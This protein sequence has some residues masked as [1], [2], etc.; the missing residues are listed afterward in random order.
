MGLW[1][2]IKQLRTQGVMGINQRNTDYILKYNKRQ[3]YPL[4]DNKIRTKTLAQRA[5]IGVP[6]LYGV[7][8][9]ERQLEQLAEFLLSLNEFVIKPSQGAAGD[10]ILVIMGRHQQGF[11]MSNGLL[12]TLEEISQQLSNILSGVYSLGGHPDVAMIEY[13]VQ[14]VE[15]FKK[16]TFQ[17][18][19]D[20][21]IIVLQGYP[22][23]AMLR[24][25]TRQSHGKAN[26]HQGAVGVGILLP[27]GVTQGGVWFND[28]IWIHPDTG[29]TLDGI[30]IPN[31][32]ECLRLAAKCYE[33]TGLGYLG[34]DIVL[35]QN[36]GPL[37][38]EI[39]AR[40]GLN[41]QVANADGLLNRLR[42]IESQTK[43]RT[44]DERLQFVQSAFA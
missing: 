43:K 37:I 41:I 22:V 5:G 27:I 32:L 33:L 6:R 26:L 11:R 38:L 3:F 34:V 31:W 24:L 40:P 28:R 2:Q 9:M 44:L 36:C 35:D 19:P 39:N 17:G 10:G 25:P 12:I 30:A 4:V 42:L 7:V 15:L 14:V 13:R 21:R 29:Q 23:M 16:I 18:V 8:S 20:I 1:Q